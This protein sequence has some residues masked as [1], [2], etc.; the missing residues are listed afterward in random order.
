MGNNEYSGHIDAAFV[1]FADQSRVPTSYV[2]GSYRRY[3]NTIQTFSNILLGNDD[4]ISDIN[5]FENSAIKRIGQT[6]GVHYG[7]RGSIY[8]TYRRRVTVNGVRAYRT[9]T[10]AF[11][12]KLNPL[13]TINNPSNFSDGGDSGGPVFVV[14]ANNR[15]NLVGLFFADNGLTSSRDNFRGYVTRITSVMCSDFGLNVTPITSQTPLSDYNFITGSIWNC[16]TIQIVGTRFDLEEVIV[17][18]HIGT[19]V[20]SMIGHRAFLNRTALRRVVFPNLIGNIHPDAFNGATN[21]E[22]IEID[23]G[24]N[25]H[26]YSRDGILYTNVRIH[27]PIELEWKE[28]RNIPPR[29]GGAVS[30]PYGVMAIGDAAFANR[31]SLVEVSI[32]SSV[33][34]IG[35]QAF[36]G[37]NVTRM[38]IPANVREIREHTF[39]FARNLER[40]TFG[41]GSQ[42]E[43]I[44]RS[45][46][47]NATS[48]ASFTIFSTVT[49][50]G[51]SAFLHMPSNFSVTWHYNP[52]MP[53]ASINNFRQ[54]LT[55]VIIP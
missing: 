21:L 17:P 3:N 47:E 22:R 33:Q 18:S 24:G 19:K 29:L 40:V 5:E 46:F 27:H 31:S 36:L 15:L 14:G 10:N 38:H 34:E 50:I 12:I 32:P 49:S 26:Y 6:T 53:R 41:E 2:R 8:A 37:T 48:L 43:Y 13:H 51:A 23:G 1:R 45:A 55:Q 52:T 30:I 39:F 4:Q 9:I 20:V 28:F 35:R 16:S 42:L 25:F 11:T 7:R 44:G 54:Y